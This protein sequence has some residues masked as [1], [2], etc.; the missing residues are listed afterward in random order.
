[1]SD[2][3]MKQRQS[4][5]ASYFGDPQ[6]RRFPIMDQ[7]DVDAASHLIGRAKGINK[8]KVRRRIMLIAKRKGLKH[9]EAWEKYETGELKD[10]DD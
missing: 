2:I 3:S 10:D 9:P 8:N 7:S 4:M 5:D 1:M 6:G